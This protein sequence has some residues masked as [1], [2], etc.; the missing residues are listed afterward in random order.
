MHFSP[1]RGVAP[2]TLCLSA[3]FPHSNYPD[4]AVQD[5]QQSCLSCTTTFFIPFAPGQQQLDEQLAR[6]R[7]FNCR[8]VPQNE[9]QPNGV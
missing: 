1:T 6:V 5:Q 3:K 7:L 8:R 9:Q 2:A 4:Y